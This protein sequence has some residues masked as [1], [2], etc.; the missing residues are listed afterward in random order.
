MSGTGPLRPVE[1]DRDTAPFFAAVREGRLIYRGCNGCGR[2]YH[3]PMPSCS[4]CGSTDTVWREAS[5][6]GSLFSSTIAR[7]QMH[8]AYPV[9]YTIVVVA[10]DDA[11]DVRLIGRIDDEAELAIGTPMI[12]TFP[13]P[14]GLPLP[15][16]Q[17]DIDSSN[18]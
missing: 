16:W 1:D 11:P 15:N 9:P 7:R 12:A 18:R 13:P 8:P 6:K 17:P 14:V 10:L 3:P 5:G 2:G 4:H